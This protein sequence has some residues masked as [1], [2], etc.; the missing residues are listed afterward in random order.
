MPEHRAD[1]AEREAAKTCPGRTVAHNKRPPT[2][3]LRC[4]IHVL[5]GIVY[6]VLGIQNRVGPGACD[7][8]PRSGCIQKHD[9]FPAAGG[10]NNGI[11]DPLIV[12][13]PHLLA[14][15][16]EKPTWRVPDLKPGAGLKYWPPIERPY[17]VAAVGGLALRSWAT[18]VTSWA[19]ANGFASM[20]LLGTPFDAHSSA[21]APLV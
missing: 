14:K 8:S 17:P 15:V 3:T 12:H 7:S 21:C 4:S 5:H 1:R 16:N 20:M 10:L 6:R 19:G 18:A 2:V 11:L 13:G 9:P